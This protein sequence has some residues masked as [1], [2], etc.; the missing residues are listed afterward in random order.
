[1][2]RS[3]ARRSILMRPRLTRSFIRWVLAK[4]PLASAAASPRSPISAAIAMNSAR[5]ASA[6]D[7]ISIVLVMTVG[8]LLK[9]RDRRSQPNWAV[10]A[11]REWTSARHSLITVNNTAGANGLRR[12]REAPSSRVILR[13]S[14]AGE[15]RLAK[16]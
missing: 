4:M 13:K 5:S 10:P 7:S 3:Q 15:L 9:S 11:E 12:Q 8:M 6:A 14:G 1:M 2:A 16:A